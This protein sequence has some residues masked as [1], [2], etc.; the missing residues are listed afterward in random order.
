[1]LDKR[2][3]NKVLTNSFTRQLRKHLYFDNKLIVTLM[4]EAIKVS[5]MQKRLNFLPVLIC[6]DIDA[7]FARDEGLFEGEIVVILSKRRTDIPISY[8]KHNFV[9]W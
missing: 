5:N 9:Q 6:M 2:V 4:T 8:M 7:Y 1:M 3:C